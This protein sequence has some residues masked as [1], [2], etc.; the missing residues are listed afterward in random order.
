MTKPLS[1]FGTKVEILRAY[2]LRTSN[3][4]TC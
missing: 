1:V 4:H 2:I 3:K